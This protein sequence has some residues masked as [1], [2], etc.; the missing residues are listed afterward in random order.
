[1]KTLMLLIFLIN[2]QLR[3]QQETSRTRPQLTISVSIEPKI[4]ISKCSGES[5]TITCQIVDYDSQLPKTMQ[6]EQT[7]R[8]YGGYVEFLLFR[9]TKPDRESV[10]SDV[11]VNYPQELLRPR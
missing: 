4:P 5:Q 1:M 7:N 8:G 2:F 6:V 11:H 3:L 9:K 10:V